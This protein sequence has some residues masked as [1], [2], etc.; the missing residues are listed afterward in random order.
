MRDGGMLGEKSRRISITDQSV[1]FSLV[2]GILLFSILFS[3]A[4]LQGRS[5]AV[6]KWPGLFSNNNPDSYIFPHSQARN[7]CSLCNCRFGHSIIASLAHSFSGKRQ[8]K[9]EIRTTNAYHL[10]WLAPTSDFLCFLFLLLVEFWSSFL[11]F[12]FLAHPTRPIHWP[13]STL[14]RLFTTLSLP[15]PILFFGLHFLRPRFN[16]TYF[17]MFA[18]SLSLAPL[19]QI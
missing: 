5:F 1:D 17:Q 12:L 15:P 2:C 7:I 3:A 18:N 16:P 8:Y 10:S 14:F 9:Y 19:P 13:S 6:H 4:I 11:S